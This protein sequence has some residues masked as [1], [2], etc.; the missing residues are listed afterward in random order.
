MNEPAELG[1]IGGVVLVGD[2]RTLNGDENG[3]RA[4]RGGRG[5]DR[6]RRGS[7]PRQK[8]RAATARRWLARRR[9]RVISLDQPLAEAAM[10]QT[11]QVPEKFL[12]VLKDKKAF[13]FL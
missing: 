10:A 11:T 9:G 1:E 13:A 6:P 3:A 8:S 2:S 5:H 12:P 4:R 7:T